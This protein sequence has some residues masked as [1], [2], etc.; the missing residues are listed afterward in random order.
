M[1]LISNAESIVSTLSRHI[2]QFNA[3]FKFRSTTTERGSPDN[4]AY[5]VTCIYVPCT[6]DVALFDVTCCKHQNTYSF[7][8]YVVSSI[9]NYD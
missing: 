6:D 7:D 1:F 8:R 5:D 2:T 9:R 4:S 3:F